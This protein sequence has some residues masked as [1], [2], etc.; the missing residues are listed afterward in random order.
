MHKRQTGKEIYDMVR[1]IKF[2]K[3]I[4]AWNYDMVRSIKCTKDK[5]SR[6]FMIW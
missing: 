4:L 6:K 1:S 2:T 3:D 5:L